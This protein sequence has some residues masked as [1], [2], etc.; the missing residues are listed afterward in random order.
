MPQKEGNP[1]APTWN[2]E[3]VFKGTALYYARYRPAY[4]DEVINLLIEKF[5]LTKETLVLDLGCG[6]G[7]ISLQLAPH[8]SQVVAIDPQEEM[9]E[10]GKKAALTRV[11]TNV[12][13]LK[14]ESGKLPEMAPQIREVSLT[15]IARAFHWMDREQ[16]LADLFKI[17]LPGGGVAIIADSSIFEDSPL[18]WKQAIVQTVQKWVGVERKAGTESTFT[19][20]PKP[21]ET[22]LKESRFCNLEIAVIKTERSW[23]V[24]EIIGYM[25]STSLASIP[26]LGDKKEA[27]E[28]D[29]R[30]ELREIE[31]SGQ[32][33]EPV[34][35][36]I[37]MVWKNMQRY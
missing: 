15:V 28:V 12:T 34:T 26:V 1:P 11:I 4:P 10:E 13:W 30:R 5:K 37:M 9:L 18:A 23:T 35:V 16:T 20:P 17:T 6:T 19:H 25:Y 31:P 21:F 2:P 27:F 33:V 8:V 22:Y 32:F 14:G 29:L 36:K 24:E 7:Q 3:N